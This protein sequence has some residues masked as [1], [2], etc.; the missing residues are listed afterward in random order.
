MSQ[1]YLASATGL[2]EATDG[3]E[4]EAVRVEEDGESSIRELQPVDGVRAVT[5]VP[6][7]DSGEKTKVLASPR[8][9]QRDLMHSCQV[10]RLERVPKGLGREN[11]VI[12]D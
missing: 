11:Y 6:R 12:L 3:V 5:A 1:G 10:D 2:V 8:T 7:I 9:E 4:A